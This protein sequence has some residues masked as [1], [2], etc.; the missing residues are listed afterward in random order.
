MPNIQNLL[1]SGS[2]RVIS[3][4]GVRVYDEMEVFEMSS[5]VCVK[6]STSKFGRYLFAAFCRFGWGVPNHRSM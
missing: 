3:A 1:F 6:M 5:N 2:S 4:S